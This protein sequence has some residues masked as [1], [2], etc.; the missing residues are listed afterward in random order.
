MST[1]STAF[2]CSSTSA[3][4]ARSFRMQKPDPK[5]GKAWCVPPAVLQ[6][7]PCCSASSAVSRVPAWQ[8]DYSRQSGKGFHLLCCRLSHAVLPAQLSAEYLRRSRL[9]AGREAHE[10][11]GLVIAA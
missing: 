6:A 5:D 8:Q 2:L 11:K 3:V 4:T 10:H 9:T 7:K 1:L